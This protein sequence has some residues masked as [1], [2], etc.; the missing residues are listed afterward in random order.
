MS[1][2]YNQP[3]IKEI[4]ENGQV[5]SLPDIFMVEDVAL[6]VKELEHKIQIQKEYKK[7]RIEAINNEIDALHRK[8]M[9]Y[10]KIIYE[11]LAQ[12][13][14]QRINFPDSCRI[15]MLKAKPG[16][17]I[18][19]EETFINFIK[20]LDNKEGTKEL[21]LIAEKIE[22]YKIKKKEANKLLDALEKRDNVPVD[23]VSRIKGEPSVA[24]KYIDTE[25]EDDERRL[26][27][28]GLIQSIDAISDNSVEDDYDG[29]KI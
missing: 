22:Q 9:F 28:G 2:I 23:C 14:E 20:T 1:N 27:Q 6:M 26:E 25:R 13:K 5:M 19:D 15:H 24:I 17:T 3:E 16:W 12:N 7:K 29:I 18:E 21:E 10:K 11:T 8:I 4:F